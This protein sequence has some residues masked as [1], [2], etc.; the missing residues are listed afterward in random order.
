M[1]CKSSEIQGK[2]LRLVSLFLEHL[3]CD[4]VAAILAP[5]A[6]LHSRLHISVTKSESVKILCPASHNKEIF[7]SSSSCSCR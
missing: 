1:L 3:T 2:S 6:G 7:K 5:A 4:G